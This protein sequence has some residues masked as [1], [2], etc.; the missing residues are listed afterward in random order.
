[1]V[2]QT[3]PGKPSSGNELRGEV[4]G[5]TALPTSFVLERFASSEMI[6]LSWNANRRRKV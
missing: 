5:S 3:P 2:V 4:A 6:I 1:M